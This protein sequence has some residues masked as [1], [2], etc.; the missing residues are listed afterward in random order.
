MRS[1]PSFCRKPRANK[2]TR[3]GRVEV[4]LRVD[5]CDGKKERPVF[6]GIS[7]GRYAVRR[8]GGAALVLST[9]VPLPLARIFHEARC[10][11]REKW[12]ETGHPW[13]V[14]LSP[15]VCLGPIV[16]T[17]TVCSKFLR[18][19]SE[20]T[21]ASVHLLAQTLHVRAMF[22]LVLFLFVVTQVASAQAGAEGAQQFFSKGYAGGSGAA[23]DSSAAQKKHER[24]DVLRPAAGARSGGAQPPGAHK[25][26]AVVALLVN[27]LDKQ[28]LVA[29][30]E[31]AFTLHDRRLAFIAHIQHVGDYRNFTPELQAECDKRGIQVTELVMLPYGIDREVS[32]TW[33]VFTP[34]GRHLIQGMLSLEQCFNAFGEYDPKL[35]KESQDGGTL[36]KL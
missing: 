26:R 36:E 18:Y 27:S 7:S 22:G 19:A 10:A 32:P 28:H 30:L 25:N 3:I 15:T 14:S 20:F 6:R 12:S 24:G 16:P 13:P 5:L 34:S 31:G 9:R 8:F 21:S 33:S 1:V 35:A 29:A 4:G 17:L 2:P 11:R 23:I